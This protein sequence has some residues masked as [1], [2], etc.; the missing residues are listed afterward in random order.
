M[1]S[2]CKEKTSHNKGRELLRGI[3]IL[4]PAADPVQISYLVDIPRTDKPDD[5]FS[6]QNDPNNPAAVT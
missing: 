5:N 1:N 4:P 2:N 3:L 6:T